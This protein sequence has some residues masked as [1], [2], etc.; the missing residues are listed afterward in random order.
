MAAVTVDLLVYPLDTIKT[1]YQSPVHRHLP[2]FRGLY[3]GLAPAVLATIPSSGLFFSVYEGV[4]GILPSSS[5]GV[6]APLSNSV[7]SAC[8]EACSCLILTPAE[9]V[10]QNAQVL[11][12]SSSGGGGS[13]G[14][15]GSRGSRMAQCSVVRAFR[16][17]R[18]WR[19]LWTGYG[20]LVARNVPYTAL[21]MPLFEL[22]KPRLLPRAAAGSSDV[23]VPETVLWA[24]IAA[25]SSGS[26]AALATTPIDVV[27]TR[28]MLSAGRARAQRKGVRAV[29]KDVL[30]D[31][32][33]FCGLWRGGA[34]RCLWTFVGSGL[35]LGTYEGGRRWL[36]SRRG[37]SC[38]L[39]I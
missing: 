22:L 35:F 12:R 32:G 6:A 4:H 38:E 16:S 13:G 17:I 33:F 37:E 3:Q 24:G 25:G 9:V 21:Q 19:D 36:A 27:K 8:A 11:Q 30:R 34:M 15:S 5:A 1:R 26:V 14:G 20:V 2:L 10:K 39:A 29:V 23:S 31:E 28:V 7:A 18:T